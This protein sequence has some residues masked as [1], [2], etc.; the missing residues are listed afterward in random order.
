[1]LFSL[2]FSYTDFIA[3]SQADAVHLA[4]RVVLFFLIR[5]NICWVHSFISQASLPLGTLSIALA[6]SQDLRK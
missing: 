5:R 3:H 2:L 4:A 1:M 6:S